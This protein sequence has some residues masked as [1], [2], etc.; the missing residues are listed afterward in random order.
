M[1]AEEYRRAVDAV[2]FR[3]D[4]ARRTLSLLETRRKE[5]ASVKRFS[6]KPALIAAALVV[7]LA[8]TASAA[9]LFLSPSQVAQEAGNQALADAFETDAAVNVNETQTV[10]DYQ[11]TLMGLLP[12]Q[13]LDQVE[14]LTGQVEGAKTYAVLA[15]TR[16]DGAAIADSVPELTVSPL[17]EGYA[18]W[19]VNAWTLGG[20]TCTFA[21]NGTLYYLFECDSVEPFADHTVYLAV[22]P[23]THIP[24]SAE[25]FSFGDDG[26]IAYQSG[27]DGA[28]FTLPLDPSK[29]NPAAVAQL[30]EPWM[31]PQASEPPAD[32][33]VSPD[34]MYFSWDNDDGNAVVILQ[35]G[36]VVP[37]D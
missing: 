7:A 17:V 35:D 14:D 31:E 8:V 1:N 11:V 13:A 25:L 9:L 22:Y 18:P 23:G 33:A 21:Q 10:G 16:T 34:D 26:A 20:G 4:F 30:M 2:E 27:Q 28:L 29:A 36:S 24:P 37:A 5:T 3:P 32:E 12:G 15:Y 19:Q 6:L